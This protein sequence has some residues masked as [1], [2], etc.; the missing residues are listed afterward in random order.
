MFAIIS[1]NNF[2]IASPEAYVFLRSAQFSQNDPIPLTPPVVSEPPH[3]RAHT[4][5][6]P[7]PHTSCQ[8]LSRSLTV[9]VSSSALQVFPDNPSYWTVDD[10]LQW[11]SEKNY[12]KITIQCFKGT[13][14]TRRVFLK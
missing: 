8:F 9:P 13:P 12:G 14:P 3:V 11:L 1:Y 10:V 7:E 6:Y 2:D 4:L 5:Q